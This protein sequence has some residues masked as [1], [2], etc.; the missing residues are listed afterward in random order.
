[1]DACALGFDS[2]GG[3]ELFVKRYGIVLSVASDH[4][5]KGLSLHGFK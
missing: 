2:G 1:M 3:F 5:T 4:W